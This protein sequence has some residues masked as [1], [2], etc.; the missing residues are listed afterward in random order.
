MRHYI[1]FFVLALFFACCSCEILDDNPEDYP[2]TPAPV[3]LGE[4]AELFSALPLEKSHI[5]EVF[6]AVSSSS[7]NGYDEE[8]TLSN[9][10]AAPG[11]GVGDDSSDSTRAGENTYPVPLRELICQHLENQAAERSAMETKSSSEIWMSPEEYVKFLS[12]SDIQIYWPYYERWDGEELP[13][14]TYDPCDGSSA[15]EGYRLSRGDDGS[16]EVEKVIV[17]EEMAMASPVWVINRNDDSGYTSLEMLRKQNPG[18]GII[19]SPAA[20]ERFSSKLKGTS[21]GAGQALILKDFTMKRN[22]DSWFAGASE[23][24]VKT[25]AVEDFCAATEAEMWLYS[26]T[27]TD[28]MIVVKRN[29]VGIPQ[30]F[31]AVLVSEWTEALTHSAFLITEDDGGTK[32]SWDCTAMV[33]V[34]SKSYGFELKIPLNR[35][36][37]IVWRGQLSRK[38]IWGNVG[39]V[40]HFGDVD[41][42]FDVLDY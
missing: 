26:P 9:L 14:I 27:I 40:C 11:S 34:N 33:K 38:F 17:D 1:T 41:I 23:F 21:G 4:V 5:T 42:T 24:F 39:Q 12:S 10:F 13:V 31:N 15:N 25:G 6:D 32:V 28:F 2:D 35:R 36:D 7:V 30:P 22:Y 18:G 37:D 3:S 16:V 20:S 29:Q 8:Y 19:V